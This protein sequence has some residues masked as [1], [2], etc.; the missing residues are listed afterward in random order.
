MSMVMT[1]GRALVEQLSA[2]GVDAVFC[3]PGESYLPVLDGLYDLPHQIPVYS[4]RHDGGAAY[5][6]EAQGKLTGRPG[7][8]FVTRGPGACNAA[9][10]VHVAHQDSTPMVLFVGQV[11]TPFLGREA[12]QEIDYLHMFADV[13]KHVLQAERASDV[14]PL[15]GRAIELACSGRPGPVVVALPEDVLSAEAEFQISA[16]DIAKVS[17]VDPADLAAFQRLLAASQRPMIIIGGSQWDERSTTRLQEFAGANSIPVCCAFRRHD[18]FDN[19]DRHFAGY[20]G[21]NADPALWK[22]VEHADCIVALGTRLD[23]STTRGYGFYDSRAPDKCLIHICSD[24]SQLGRNF[25]TNLAIEADSAAFVEALASLLKFERPAWKAWCDEAHRD[26]LARSTPTANGAKLDLGKAMS[27]LNTFLPDDA[28]VTMDAGNFTAW[29]QRFRRY[30]RPGRLLAPLNGA[31]GYGVPAAVAASLVA[32]QRSVIGFVGD[33]GMLMTGN[34]LA[35]AVQY[36]A[37][38]IILVINNSMYGTIR[39]HQERAYPGR[40]I[41]TELRNPDFAALAQA[42]GAYGAVVDEDEEFAPALEEARESALPAVLELRVDPDE[43]IPGL[44]FSEMGL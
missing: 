17:N 31:M 16:P 43:T 11:E 40:S 27:V 12:V 25:E 4:C 19:T 20:L 38:P 32:P 29:P 15:A 28:I 35:T 3:V 30:R 13:A 36:G 6:A 10:A 41:A 42:F 8:C 9:I 24:P 26:F 44:R 37:C 21:L 39:L 2:A 33:G 14:A 5:M 23:Q 34:E 22:R 1:G 18:I 7:I